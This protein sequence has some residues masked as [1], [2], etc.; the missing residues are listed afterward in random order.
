MPHV[1]NIPYHLVWVNKPVFHIPEAQRADMDVT[2]L[3]ALWVC[4]FKN[5]WVTSNDINTKEPSLWPSFWHSHIVSGQGRMRQ[6][7]D[8]GKRQDVLASGE[9]QCW[10]NSC[11]SPALNL[12]NILQNALSLLSK[13]QSKNEFTQPSWRSVWLL[14]LCGRSLI[15]HKLICSLMFTKLDLETRH[16]FA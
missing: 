12:V 11:K 6:G 3:L 1:K 8:L 4:A 16:H 7:H 13:L 15:N 14:S 2:G 5:L 9:Q 10:V